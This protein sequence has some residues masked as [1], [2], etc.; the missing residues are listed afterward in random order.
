MLTGDN[1]KVAAKVAKEVGIEEFKSS[2]YPQDKAKF[3]DDY[4]DM[5]K[6]VVMVGD[7][8]ND[9][10]ALS[11]SDIAI[12]MGSGSDVSVDVSDVVLLDDDIKSLGLSYKLSKKTYTNIKQNLSISLIYNLVTIPLAVSGLVIPLI[13]AL[14]MSLSSLLVV[15]NA[16][17]INKGI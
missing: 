13:A 11:K 10:L 2:L 1:E 12:A 15:A 16:F 4:H 7:G 6:T 17:R 8:I 9:A 14:S 3:I 5:G